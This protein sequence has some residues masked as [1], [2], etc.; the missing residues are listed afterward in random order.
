LSIKESGKGER[1]IKNNEKN[2]DINSFYYFNKV[3]DFN[4][5]GVKMILILKLKTA[6][7]KT[8]QQLVLPL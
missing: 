7:I 6:T 3:L 1:N 2:S 4:W 8:R 5:L